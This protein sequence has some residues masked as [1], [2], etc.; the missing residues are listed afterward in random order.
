[1][2]HGYLAGALSAIAEYGRLDGDAALQSALAV[3]HKHREACYG[4]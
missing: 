4:A 3:G 2:F 1:M